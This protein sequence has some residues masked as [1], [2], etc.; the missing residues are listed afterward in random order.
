[1]LGIAQA[2][3]D[4]RVALVVGNDLYTSLAAD[5]QL[6]RAVNDSRAIGAALGR[7]GFGAR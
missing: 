6:R 3:A 4:K 2:R 1:L 5:Q 7:L